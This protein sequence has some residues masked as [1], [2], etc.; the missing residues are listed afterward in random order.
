M[1]EYMRQFL[2]ALCEYDEANIR[3]AIKIEKGENTKVQEAVIKMR[4]EFLITMAKQL[5]SKE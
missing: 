1:S 5:E 2:V 3:L 4:R